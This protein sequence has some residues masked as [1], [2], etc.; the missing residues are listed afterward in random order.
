MLN[1]NWGYFNVHVVVVVAFPSFFVEA[2]SLHISL[3]FE[4]TPKIML[5]KI[6]PFP[7][8]LN[9]YKN[10]EWLFAT[11]IILTK[12]PTI[13]PIKK[14]SRKILIK[15][16]KKLWVFLIFEIKVIAEFHSK[17]LNK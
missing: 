4:S 8:E 14:K 15:N 11:T 7:N 5:S 3:P 12:N 2:F 17:Y 10:I 13:L 1:I 9:F 16:L 6:A